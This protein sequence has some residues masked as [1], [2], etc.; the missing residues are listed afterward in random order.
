M[1]NPCFECY[2]RYN[3]QYTEECDENCEYANALSKLKS[4]DSIDENKGLNDMD[5]LRLCRNGGPITNRD[6]GV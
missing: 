1:Y 6:I 2:I 3:R 4:F 5:L